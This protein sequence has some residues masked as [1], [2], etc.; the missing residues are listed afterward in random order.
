MK[1]QFGILGPLEVRRHDV[2]IDLGPPKQRAVL[3]ALLI[4]SNQ[5]V[6]LDRLIEM[7]WGKEVPARAHGS[8]QAYIHN[9]RK[10]LEPDRAVRSQAQILVTRPPGYVVQVEPDALDAA[11]FELLATE[12]HRLL[13]QAHPDSAKQ[14]LTEAM[15]MWRGPALAE[16][17]FEQFAQPEAAR[18]EQ[19]RAVVHEDLLEAELAL[20]NHAAVIGDITV[21]V[22]EHPLRERLWSLLM[23][24]L[25][26]SGR[27]GEALRAFAMARHTLAEE[28][29]IDPSPALRSLESA[30][31][32]QS[33]DLEYYRPEAWTGDQYSPSPA[34]APLGNPVP[35]SAPLVGRETQLRRLTAAMSH[36]QV[37]HG[38]AVLIS[39]EAG[40]GKTRL[41]EEL[42][43]EVEG[44]G[45]LVSW[46]RAYEPEGA[47]PGWLWMQVG[48]DL[49][50]QADPERVRRALV[51]R[52]ADLRCVLPDVDGDRN[53]AED[54]A[55]ACSCLPTD[56][57]SARFRFFEAMT[58]FLVELATADLLLVVLEDLQWADQLSL[59]LLEHLTTRVQGSHVLV[60]VTCRPPENHI[61]TPLTEVVGALVRLP[62]FDWIELDGLNGTE[63]GRLMAQS[64]ARASP[65]QVT[66]IHS[67]TDGNP[68]YI[69]N[70]A[71][72][73]AARDVPRPHLAG[74]IPSSVGAAIRRRMRQ[75]PEQT[76][77]LLVIAA[78]M[79]REFD[80]R[81]VA[82][83]SGTTLDDAIN[84]VQPAVVGGVVTEDLLS[85]GTYRF[86]HGLVRETLRGEMSG[87]RRCT[88]RELATRVADRDG[89]DGDH[90]DNQKEAC[91]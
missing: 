49:L 23:L 37:G 82:A 70:F 31:L 84:Q 33:P 60:V 90:A 78:A 71:R 80:I 12:G 57:P 64:G 65:A 1:L 89:T 83:G 24:A 8:L 54:P 50:R 13:T 73:L 66:E 68:F 32:A 14:R 81:K 38:S 69:S 41:V 18:L 45:H 85:P 16:F 4:S 77:D 2:L 79:G 88:L 56:S 17:A 46:G 53:G 6:S 91:G 63:V 22:G 5:V 34:A 76:R 21:A 15:A 35:R 62:A 75:L 36:A 58:S 19:V 39:G 27:Q 86:S 87:L 25:Y 9:L 40:I 59:Q 52:T 3:A 48:A 61:E 10:V 7:L 72:L 29:G 28:L 30:I 55:R 43:A 44:D 42:A 47:P 67:R 51:G 20:G 11:K 74:L 26:R